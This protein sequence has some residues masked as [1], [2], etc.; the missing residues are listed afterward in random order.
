MWALFIHTEAWGCVRRQAVV[1]RRF[2][3]IIDDTFCFIT[4]SGS[5][6]AQF[7]ES[8]RL[9][10]LQFCTLGG[11]ELLHTDI[12]GKAAEWFH[13]CLTGSAKLP[14]HKVRNRKGNLTDISVSSD[15]DNTDPRFKNLCF[16][17]LHNKTT[18][19]S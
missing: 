9:R 17:A 19:I 15:I 18:E 7:P 11:S 8:S 16:T 1:F 14:P 3:Q 4:L 6:V 2:T 10:V 13:S 5:T 12:L